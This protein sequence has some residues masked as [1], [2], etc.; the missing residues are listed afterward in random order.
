MEINENTS[1][2]KICIENGKA[3]Y[4]GFK[5]IVGEFTADDLNIATHSLIHCMSLIAK[6]HV[7]ED[8]YP[9]FS[10]IVYKILTNH[11]KEKNELN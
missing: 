7:Q 6:N 2:I 4:E 5:E 3:L 1:D 8:N 11:L 9:Y 10:Q